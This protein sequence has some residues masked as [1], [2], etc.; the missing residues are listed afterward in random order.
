[1]A[2]SSYPNYKDGGALAFPKSPRGCGGI[3]NVSVILLFWNYG[4][5]Q[6]GLR[7][8]GPGAGNSPRDLS[9]P[10]RGRSH[11]NGGGRDR[12]EREGGARHALVPPEGARQRGAPRLPAGRPL[13]L[14]F[15]QLRADERADRL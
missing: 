15:R 9:S 12:S 10:R 6:R 3:D 11:G 4:I 5:N 13:H 14:L 2:A 7:P 1:M 8:R